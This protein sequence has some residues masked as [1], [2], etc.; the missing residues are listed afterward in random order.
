M[1]FSF[2]TIATDAVCPR[3]RWRN[4]FFL[5]LALTLLPVFADAQTDVSAEL[6]PAVGEESVLFHDIP[7]VFGASKY[8]QKVTEAPSSITIIT[9]DEIKKYGHRTLSD[10]LQS[11]N[12]F[13]VT[14][15]RN[16]SYIGARGFNRPGDYNTRLLL[17]VD[18][19]RLNDSV[20]DQAPGGTEAPVDID[21]ID[22]VEIIRGPSSSL[23]GTNAFFGVINVITKRG[24][25]IKGVELSAEV[26]SYESHK[27]RFTLGTQFENGIEALLSGSYY[28]SRGHNR[29][30]YKEFKVPGLSNGIARNA[31][32]DGSYHLFGKLSWSDFTL[33]GSYHS[34][35]KKIPTAAFSSVFNTDRTLTKDEHGY[36]DL[37][38]QHLFADQ[39]DVFARLYYDRY[40]YRGDYLFD[41]S[42]TEEPLITLN[43][44]ITL[45]E[46][47][48]AE[49][50]VTRRFFE[51]HRVTVGHEY[52][53]NMIQDQRNYD[54]S[55]FASYLHDQ[56]SLR[57][58]AFY[59]QDEF[60]I[61]DNL[62]LNG[63]VRYDHYD[64]FGG[65]TNPRVALIY[66]LPSTSIKLLYGEAFRAPNPFEQYYGSGSVFQANPDLAPEEITTYEFVV[67][68][69]LDKNWRAAMTGYYYTIDGLIGQTE[70]ED[71][72]L[73]FENLEN[74][75]AKGL[76]FELDGKYESGIEGRVSYALQEAKN[77]DSGEKLTNSPQHIVKLALIYPVIA[78]KLYAGL[79]SQYMSERRTLS[80]RNTR[81]HFLTNFTLFNQNLIKG[82]EVSGSVFNLFDEAYGDPGSGEHRQ[83][84][85]EQDGRTFWLKLKYAF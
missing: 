83:E 66:N 70:T 75:E 2:F 62:I 71:G 7:S 13:F 5:G 11:V 61:L 32:E 30:F 47:W 44:D 59:F 72:L 4:R 21:L 67:E 74:I 41:Y 25:D 40:Y 52:R 17:L 3:S 28:D 48:G 53:D 24:R 14:N 31:D 38:Y 76:E 65:T 85:I 60:A 77:Q 35:E 51:K 84:V 79:E 39:W 64:T 1:H 45:A 82:L 26:G 73:T 8:E 57:I 10:I 55:P 12:G 68:H 16:Y 18:G 78:D 63:G 37:K 49:L 36:V 46:W 69:H 19:H 9:A 23:Y 80:G 27:G 81:G 56:R 6:P 33:Q 15:D 29:L 58:W 50:K 43:R 22:R 54:V 20:F 42:E 34:R